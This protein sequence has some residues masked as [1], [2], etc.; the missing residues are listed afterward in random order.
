M[1]ASFFSCSS[2]Y[3]VSRRHPLDSDWARVSSDPVFGVIPLT[4]FPKH[5]MSGN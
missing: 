1:F 3:R 5:R 2:P 4:F